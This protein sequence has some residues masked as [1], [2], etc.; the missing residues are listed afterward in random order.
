MAADIAGVEFA[1]A[2]GLK[3]D[4]FFGTFMPS[5]TSLKTPSAGLT[6]RTGLT[7]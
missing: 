1:Y 6:L 4:F 3:I 5:S 2:E 7:A